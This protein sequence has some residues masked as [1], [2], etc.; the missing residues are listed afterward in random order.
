[1]RSPFAIA[2]IILGFG[3]IPASDAADA[4]HGG[5]VFKKCAMCHAVEAGKNSGI[6]PNLAGVIG[7]RAGAAPYN[8]SS[9]MKAAG[10]VWTPANLDAF[11]AQPKTLVKGNKMIFAGLTNAADRADV[12]AFLATKK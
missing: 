4:V 7:R 10:L 5:V 12:I 3:F 6:G 9:A 2:V 1:M 11:L 8:Y